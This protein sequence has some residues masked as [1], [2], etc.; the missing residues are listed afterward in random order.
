MKLADWVWPGDWADTTDI[1][2]NSN[3]KA[4]VMTVILMGFANLLIFT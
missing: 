3:A 1:E 2:T 4:A